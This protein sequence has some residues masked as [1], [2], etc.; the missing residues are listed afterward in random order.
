MGMIYELDRIE[1]AAVLPFENR[2]TFT[3]EEVM[4][5]TEHDR[6]RKERAENCDRGDLGSL[7]TAI[8]GLQSTD[9]PDL[10][11]LHDELQERLRQLTTGGRNDA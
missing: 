1:R 3:N 6:I 9:H 2:T 11:P 8:V 7:R 5:M 4:S 10:V